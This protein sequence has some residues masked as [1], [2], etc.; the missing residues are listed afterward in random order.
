MVNFFKISYDNLLSG[1]LK[2][3]SN[4]CLVKCQKEPNTQEPER[5]RQGPRTGLPPDG[6]WLL[7]PPPL[8]PPHPRRGQ[9]R[10]LLRGEPLPPLPLRRRLRRPGAQFNGQLKTLG[11][12]VGQV[13]GQLYKFTALFIC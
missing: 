1:H 6:A 13:L 11:A 3:T 7:H 8:L 4:Q 5:R 10:Q 12:N 9:G 2:L